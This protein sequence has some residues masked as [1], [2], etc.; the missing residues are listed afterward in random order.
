[1]KR[2]DEAISLNELTHICST[3]V[4]FC[5]WDPSLLLSGVG[6]KSIKRFALV[7]AVLPP[8]TWCCSLS[9]FY[10]TSKPKPIY[11]KRNGS[12]PL[13][14]LVIKFIIKEDL[15]IWNWQAGSREF[16]WHL[17]A[18]VLKSWRTRW[19]SNVKSNRRS[20]E[21]GSPIALGLEVGGAKPSGPT[22][23]APKLSALFQF[24]FL[25]SFSLLS[26]V[27]NLTDTHHQ[28]KKN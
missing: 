28:Q 10:S 24:F 17:L 1:M 18:K 6:F 15:G 19:E 12:S 7:A 14:F 3:P 11:T 27:S 25:S 21:I 20:F 9:F 8:L 2:E 13:G 4:H 22:V 5:H 16:G 23:G 26:F